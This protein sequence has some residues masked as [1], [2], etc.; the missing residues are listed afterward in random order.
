MDDQEKLND[1]SPG[2]HRRIRNVKSQAQPV[3]VVNLQ[4]KE[5]KIK[6][7]IAEKD[8]IK[9]IIDQVS[10]SHELSED[11]KEALEAHINKKLE[12]E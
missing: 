6:I 11:L 2:N 10:V 8:N 4:F 5:K 3:L 1:N 7:E 9:S 12:T